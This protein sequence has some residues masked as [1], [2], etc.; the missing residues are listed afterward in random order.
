MCEDGGMEVVTI[1]AAVKV[2]VFL[3]PCPSIH[4]IIADKPI[5]LGPLPS[6]L[7]TTRRTNHVRDSRYHL[8]SAFA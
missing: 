5:D 1:D 2:L 4:F 8:F 6:S 3:A 7:R